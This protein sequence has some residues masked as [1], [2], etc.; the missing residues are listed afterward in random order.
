MIFDFGCRDALGLWNYAA[1]AIPG[2]LAVFAIFVGLALIGR[3]FTRNLTFQAGDILVGW[4]V[5]A[6]IM[7]FSVV[8][9]TK[10]LFFVALGLFALMLIGL[11]P[12]LKSRYFVAPF[13]ILALFPGLFVLT[14]T[15][16]IGIGDLAWDD[17]SHWVPNALYVFMHDDLPTKALPSVH[18][19]WPGYPYALPFLTYL[20]SVLAGGF[21]IQGGAMINFFLLFV[22]AAALVESTE[23]PDQ[24]TPLSWRRIGL[25][26]LALIFATLLSSTLYTPVG[27]GITNQGDTATMVLCGILGLWFWQLAEMLPAD[28][29]TI[30]KNNSLRLGLTSL[31]FVLAKQVNFVLLAFLAAAFLMIAWRNKVLKSALLQLPM[32]LLPALVLRIVWQYYVDTEIAGNGFAIMPFSRWRF[33][34]FFQLLGGI[35]LEIARRCV[36]FILFISTLSCGVFS[37]RRPPTPW[38]NLALFGAIMQIGYASFLITAYVGSNFTEHEIKIASCFHRYMLHLG[39][40]ALAV[41][42]VAAPGFWAKLKIYSIAIPPLAR[43]S[44]VLA[45]LLILPLILSFQTNLVVM[46]PGV[47]MCE[48]RKISHEIA[49]MLPANTK[50]GVVATKSNGM[51]PVVISLELALQEARTGRA[52]TLDWHADRYLISALTDAPAVVKQQ[53]NA[54][55]EINALVYAQEDRDLIKNLGI[56]DTL[57]TGVLLREGNEWK[58]IQPGQP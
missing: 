23:K 39:F 31:A 46:K 51:V 40:L 57:G 14:A 50:L 34:M 9:F 47:K 43:K 44:V 12:I 42:W 41:F 29:E 37:L 27:L 18:S 28:D 36:F 35:V 13:W 45:S 52:M 2:A 24:T 58:S 16:A 54:H 15:N 19:V 3:F 56:N 7:T 8:L 32:I 53:L 25:T 20:A 1:P 48:R 49:K 22:F 17:F 5:A 38:R 21:L 55:P 4:G 6:G 26:S 10:P 33:D 30:I 11:I